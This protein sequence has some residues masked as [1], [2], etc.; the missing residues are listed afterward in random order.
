MATTKALA[1]T[2]RSPAQAPAIIEEGEYVISGV[3]SLAQVKQ[4]LESG[5]K[6]YLDD[7]SS[8]DTGS[9]L[10][11]T[12]G[13]ADTPEGL[14]AESELLSTKDHLGEVFIIEGI[15]AVRPSDYDEPGSLGVYLVVSAIDSDGELVKLSVGSKDAFAKII[16]LSEMGSLPWRVSFEKAEKATKRGFFP[17]N[18]VN[19]QAT[20][21]S[22]K[23]VDF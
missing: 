4:V 11:S 22:G 7:T 17:I 23:K 13:R 2:K 9:F 14:F 15:D 1:T 10:A 18:L 19:R 20:T 8:G 12:L 16:A 3:P 5:S 21:K 6:F